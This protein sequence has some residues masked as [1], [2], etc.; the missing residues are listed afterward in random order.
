MIS[1]PNVRSSYYIIFAHRP[2]FSLETYYFAVFAITKTVSSIS[3]FCANTQ[4]SITN[5]CV[6]WQNPPPPLHKQ[7]EI[8][9]KYCIKTQPQDL[10]C[11]S[12]YNMKLFI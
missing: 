12:E 8:R 2:F 6:A 9:V 10:T 11:G 5:V 7:K 3:I 4:A 1:D